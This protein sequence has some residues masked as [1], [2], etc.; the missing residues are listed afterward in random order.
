[1]NKITRKF[2]KLSG[3]TKYFTGKPCK[4]GHISERNTANG[5]CLTCVKIKKPAADK[6]YRAAN[7]EIIR[8]YDRMR[9]ARSRNPKKLKAAKKRYYEKHKE[10]ILPKMKLLS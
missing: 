5:C 2:A 9:A 8:E 6:K 3:L 10:R 4:H 1:M 7:I